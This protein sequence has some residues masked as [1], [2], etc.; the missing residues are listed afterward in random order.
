M[1]RYLVRIELYKA[2]ADKYNSLHDNMVTLGFS[3]TIG[4]SAGSNLKLPHGTYTGIS[5]LPPHELMMKV[6][7]IAGLLS[8][9]EP[10]VMV[11]ALSKDNWAAS[12]NPE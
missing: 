9:G 5:Y 7:S 6:R 3:Q 12:L 11:V 2:D 10:S 1:V 4:D 8:D